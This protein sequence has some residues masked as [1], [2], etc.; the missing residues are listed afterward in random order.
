MKIV[1]KNYYQKTTKKI[2]LNKKSYRPRVRVSD[3][4]N[5]KLK[6]KRKLN[7][8]LNKKV[9]DRGYGLGL[10]VTVKKKL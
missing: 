8:K 2:K 7:K 3:N 4:S 5:S 9:T 1:D 6:K 10:T